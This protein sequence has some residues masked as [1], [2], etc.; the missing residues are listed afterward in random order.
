MFDKRGLEFR[1][2]EIGFFEGRV[3]GIINRINHSYDL[4]IY[5]SKKDLPRDLLFEGSE[6][7]RNIDIQV[8]SYL[9][10]TLFRDAEKIAYEKIKKLAR[11]VDCDVVVFDNL[12][13]VHEG[14][15][16]FVRLGNRTVRSSGKLLQL[17]FHVL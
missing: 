2:K 17:L 16:L 1:N 13:Y 14:R 3:R 4:K 12:C 7:C 6:F 9:S 11:R 5:G 15:C 10:K 8:P